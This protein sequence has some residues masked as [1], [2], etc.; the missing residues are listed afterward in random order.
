MKEELSRSAM[1]LGEDAVEFPEN[2]YHGN[3]IKV[4]AQK[5]F[6]KNGVLMTAIYHPAALLR[7]VSKRP[8]TFEDLKSIQSKVR[9]LCDH[10]TI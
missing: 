1:L 5:F 9:E 7:D 8:E 10:T 3:D 2:G 4:L 6:E